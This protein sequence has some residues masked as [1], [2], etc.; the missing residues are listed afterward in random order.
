MQWIR[1]GLH[2]PFRHMRLPPPFIQGASLLDATS[3]Q[4][5]FV[6]AQLAARLVEARAWE[7]CPNNNVV[8]RL[9]LV[10]KPGKNHWRLI[11]DLRHMNDQCTRKSLKMETLLG[12]RYLTRRCDHMF[13][14]DLQDG[15]F[16]LGIVQ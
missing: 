15:F 2:V 3:E 8:S 10:S 5:A 14:F 1:E 4:P 7:H 6:D 9:F 13:S 11:C 12:V 16:A